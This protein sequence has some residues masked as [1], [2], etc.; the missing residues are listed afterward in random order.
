MHH[1]T[2]R[3]TH[4]RALVTPVVDHWL[5]RESTQ[6]DNFT[7]RQC[8]HKHFSNVVRLNISPRVKQHTFR[9]SPDRKKGSHLSI[10]ADKSSCFYEPHF[11]LSVKLQL[12]REVRVDEIMVQYRN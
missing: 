3:I 11:L 12:V 7:P 6:V 8:F 2:D 4:T 5:E 10:F 1:P 9:I